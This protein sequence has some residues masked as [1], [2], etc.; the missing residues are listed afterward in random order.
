MPTLDA[1]SAE[2][3]RRVQSR[4]PD[5]QAH[6]PV[7]YACVLPAGTASVRSHHAKPRCHV[8]SVH[9]LEH[10]PGALQQLLH[11]LWSGMIAYWAWHITSW[12]NL[13]WCHRGASTHHNCMPLGVL[14]C[15]SIVSKLVAHRNNHCGEQIVDRHTGSRSSM[16][17]LILNSF[18]QQH[19]V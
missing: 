11:Q 7:T 17:R 8:C 4:Q 15:A 9:H 1:Q 12:F 3:W 13:G 5:M 19:D 18:S 2:N 10:H 14:L 16:H 6:F